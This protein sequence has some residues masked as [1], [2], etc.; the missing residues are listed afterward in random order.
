MFNKFA[1]AVRWSI[2]LGM[3][4]T[5]YVIAFKD[6]IEFTNQTDEK[7]LVNMAKKSS[8]RTEKFLIYQQLHHLYPKNESYKT[9]YRETIKVQA[10][11]V[12]FAHNKMLMPEPKGNYKYIEEIEFGEDNNGSFILLFNMTKEFE[13]LDH[14]T[15]KTLQSMFR[16]THKG[17]YEHYGFDTSFKLL[18][19]PTFDTKEGIN[20][21][22]LGSKSI[23]LKNIKV[24]TSGVIS[25]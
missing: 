11:G 14:Q 22:E 18:I 15:Q 12:L 13:Q 23:N 20:V 2:L 25:N 17:I 6:N 19:I 24:P 5:L 1:K 3:L 7:V 10:E 9:S 8:K 21:M 4:Y 16:I